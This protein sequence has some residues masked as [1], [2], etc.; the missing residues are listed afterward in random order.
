MKSAEQI[1]KEIQ[2]K[3]EAGYNCAEGIFWGLMQVLEKNVAVSVVTGFGGGMG[4]TGSVCGALTGAIAAV[5]VA[6]GRVEPE[7]LEL[8]TN[9]NALCATIIADFEQEMGSQICQEILGHLPGAGPATTGI[10]PKCQQA[11]EVALRVTLKQLP[12]ETI[13]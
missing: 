1:F 2:I 8:K 11:V 6:F 9:C 12:F 7:E 3:R 5:G 10:H 13:D 4:G